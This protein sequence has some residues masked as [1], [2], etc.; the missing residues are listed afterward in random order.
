MARAIENWSDFLR[1]PT[2]VLPQIERGEEV[3][4]RRRDGAALRLGLESEAEASQVGTEIAALVLAKVLPRM[5]PA[6]LAEALRPRLPWSRFLPAPAL[7]EFGREFADTLEACASIGNM[8][9]IAE[10][11]ADWK[12]TAEIYADPLLASDL[13]RPLPGTDTR[14]P[15]PASGSQER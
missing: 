10:V 9:R 12:V 2:R 8:N 13:R 3:I 11:L 5:D 14:V 4:L 7:E 6:L 15:R 1:E